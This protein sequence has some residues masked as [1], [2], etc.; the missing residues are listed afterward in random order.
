MLF[1]NRFDIIK[2][3]RGN[4]EEGSMLLSARLLVWHLKK[5]WEVLA[6]GQLTAEPYLRYAVYYREGMELEKGTV[7]VVDQARFTVP[8]HQLSRYLFV[9]AGD[10]FQIQVEDYPNMCVIPRG[11]GAD[12]MNLL[13]KTFHKYEE[14]NQKLF[15]ASLVNASVQTLLDLTD[16]IIPNPMA[17][18]GMDFKVIAV[19]HDIF[20]GLYNSTLGSDEESASLV[21]TLKQDPNYEEAY[22]RVGYFY[23]PGNDVATPSLCVNIRR[24]DHT[25]YR[26]LYMEGEAPLD[27]TFGFVLEH[28][29]RM[30]SH[31]F[32][33]NIVDSHDVRHQLH[34]IFTTVLTDSGADYVEVSHQLSSHGWQS[35][36]Y[37]ICILIR[38]GLLD[39]KNLTFRSLCSYVENAIPASCAI[40]H[41]ENVVVYINLD[42]CR[43]TEDEISQKLAG[44]IRDSFLNAGYSRRLLGHFNFQRQ[45]VQASIAL[46]VGSRKNPHRWIHHFNDIALPYLLEQTT[47]RLP[48]YMVCHEKLLALKYKSEE[49][50]SQLY[51]T[52]RCYLENHQ[53]ITKTAQELYIHR[54]TLLYRLDRIQEI[55]KSD[56]TDPDEI[57][58]LLLSFR[59]I[60][61]EEQE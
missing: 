49:T 35:S 52:L 8:S 15:E 54:S 36:H 18:V 25:V 51:R 39:L 58:Y 59:L 31:A 53:S 12:I 33:N 5:D 4:K 2:A 19:K 45:Y 23:Y 43:M 1:K 9:L 14:W 37:Y 61:M 20:Q 6:S 34:Q 3:I 21:F 26:L 10:H 44:F 16:P 38:T 46:K 32:S 28:L 30:I 60:E 56:Y 47:K 29:A 11:N 57:L 22:H 27:E 24:F 48:A 40:V 7:Y 55:L 17:V 41:R 42:L 13:S 50:N